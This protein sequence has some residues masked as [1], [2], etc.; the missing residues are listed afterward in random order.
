MT[1]VEI[2]ESEQGWGQRVDEVREFK[3]RD[4]AVKFITEYNA[5]NGRPVVPG[6]YMY[7]RIVE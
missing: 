3:T 7:A 2:I 6:W 4:K 1:K 5:K